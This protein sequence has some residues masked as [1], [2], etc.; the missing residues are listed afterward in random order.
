MSMYRNLNEFKIKIILVLTAVSHRFMSCVDGEFYI[1]KVYSNDETPYTAEGVS[2]GND[3]TY[4]YNK[5]RYC[6]LNVI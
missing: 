2:L 4:I 3:D 1:L 5:H 6:F